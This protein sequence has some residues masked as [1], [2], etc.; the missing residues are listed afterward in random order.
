MAGKKKKT[1]ANKLAKMSDEERARYM[2]HRADIEEE[3]KRRKEQLISTFMKNRY[4]EKLK[5]EYQNDLEELLNCNKREKEMIM[6]NTDREEDHLKTIV[7]GQETQAKE[8]IR[9]EYQGY[10]QMCYETEC[11]VICFS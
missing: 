1:L 4:V 11:E 2:Q 8:I 3:A 10:M 5:L 6:D 9:S 7:Y